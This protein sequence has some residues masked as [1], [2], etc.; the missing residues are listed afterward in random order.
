VSVYKR[1]NGKK[2]TSRDP[3]YEKATWYC[4]TRVNGSP[5]HRALD[6]R[7]KE[8]AEKEER[9]LVDRLLS[10]ATHERGFSDF[11]DDVYVRY[12]QSLKSRYTQELFIPIFKD[13]FKNKLLHRIT[14][15]DCR[16]FRN[17]RQRVLTKGGEARSAASLNREMAGLSKIFSLAI[18]EECVKVNPVARVK[19]LKEDDPRRRILSDAQLVAVW[20]EL[21][22]DQYLRDVFTIGSNFPIRR[23]QVLAIKNRDIDIENRTL[24][25][26]ESKG[27]PPRPLFINDAALETLERLKNLYSG[28]VFPM[29]CFQ[30]RWQKMLVRA[31]VNQEGGSRKDNFHFHDLRTQLGT[32]MILG[33][34]HP[35]V[36]QDLFNHSDMK[37]STIYMAV[38]FEQQKQALQTVGATNLATNFIDE[39][40]KT[41]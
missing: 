5:V 17:K 24:W 32:R 22:Q 7:T 33:G 14:P 20:K 28:D 9:D 8:Q 19:R 31:G 41:Q 40:S 6:A 18:E 26:R 23:A 38:E 25:A 13:H 1:L 3:G 37:T 34:T 39:T 35:R 10:G 15:Q 21:G 36:V 11:V 27:K 30:K 2:V 12:I 4:W 29:K 16:D